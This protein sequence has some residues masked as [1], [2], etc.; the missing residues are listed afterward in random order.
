MSGESHIGLGF[1]LLSV[2]TRSKE[3]DDLR[4][5]PQASEL[6][7]PNICVGHLRGKLLAQL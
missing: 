4:M 2:K 7:G 1:V 5:A 6:E 3:L